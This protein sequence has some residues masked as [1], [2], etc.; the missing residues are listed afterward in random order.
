MSEVPRWL[1][2]HAKTKWGIMRDKDAAPVQTKA[3]GAPRPSVLVEGT[4][5][6][7][8]QALGTI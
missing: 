4:A 3:D 5:V 2:F 8:E 6:R 1:P 7:A